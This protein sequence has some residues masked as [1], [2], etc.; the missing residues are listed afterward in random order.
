[1]DEDYEADIVLRL[2]TYKD[3]MRKEEK[4]VRNEEGINRGETIRGRSLGERKVGINLLVEV[5]EGN[6]RNVK[7]H[8]V[9]PTTTLPSRMAKSKLSII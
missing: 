6:F 9:A 8:R 2:I 5:Y 4:R 3:L 1:M 7:E